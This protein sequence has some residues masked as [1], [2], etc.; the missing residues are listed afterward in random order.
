M[1]YVHA[2]VAVPGMAWDERDEVGLGWG[3]EVGGLSL[4]WAAAGRG[5]PGIK[6]GW[7]GLGGVR[8]Y[9]GLV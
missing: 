2:Y 5:W 8:C 7:P 6:R 9:L 1:L 3:D 4:A